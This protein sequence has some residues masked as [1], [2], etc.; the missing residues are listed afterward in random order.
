MPSIPQLFVRMALEEKIRALETERMQSQVL[1]NTLQEE[2]E[3]E[4]VPSES[5]YEATRRMMVQQAAAVAAEKERLGT[6]KELQQRE[7]ERQR[8]QVSVPCPHLILFASVDMLCDNLGTMMLSPR[9]TPLIT[10]S[11][12]GKPLIQPLSLLHEYTVQTNILFK[13]PR[14]SLVHVGG[15]N[16]RS[17]ARGRRTTSPS[18]QAARNRGESTCRSVGGAAGDGGGSSDGVTA[19]AGDRS[20]RG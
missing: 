8:L 14:L 19:A 13:Q 9:M 7:M 16:E 12:R 17:F 18:G 11:Q 3:T 2:A 15:G 5:D 10:Y 6:E 20:C 1:Q 4:A